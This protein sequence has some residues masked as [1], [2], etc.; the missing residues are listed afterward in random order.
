MERIF[1]RTPVVDPASRL[2]IFI[3]D[4]SYLPSPDL[5]NYD[6]F[7]PT[8]MKYLPQEPYALV[9]FNCGL[10]KVPWVW[11]IKFLKQFLDDG[12]YDN[13]SRLLKIYTV[14]DSWFVRSVT[15]IFSTKLH[16][17]LLQRMLDSFTIAPAPTSKIVRCASLSELALHLDITSLKISLNVYKYNRQ[18][19]LAVAPPPSPPLN[20]HHLYQLLN[21]LDANAAKCELIFHKPGNK[22]NTDILQQC[23][24]RDQLIWINDWDLWCIATLFKRILAD[25]PQALLPL[26]SIALP[27]H[28]DLEYTMG[29]WDL[30]WRQHHQRNALL[31]YD[32]LLCQFFNLL[33]TLVAH[34]ATTKH[35]TTLL[36]RCVSHCLSHEVVLLNKDRI[37][38]VNRFVRNVLDNWELIAPLH[39][40]PSVAELALPHSAQ[41][42][43]SYDVSYNVTIDNDDEDLEYRVAFNTT[44]ILSDESLKAKLQS[45]A[46]PVRREAKHQPA[47][48]ISQSRPPKSPIR[49]PQPLPSTHNQLDTPPP[50]PM[51]PSPQAP[52]KSH[53]PSKSVIDAPIAKAPRHAASKL[54]SEPPS[55]DPA[56]RKPLTNLKDVSNVVPQFP[57]Q[58]YRFA[59]PTTSSVDL[60]ATPPDSAASER[61]TS[62]V[63]KPVIRGRKVGELAR[64]FEERAEALEVLK[65]MH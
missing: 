19:D 49:T 7:I 54:V 1:Y 32:E 13:L 52:P 14:H 47:T 44:T 22:V 2:P 29:S 15:Q 25:L 10:N 28:D 65:T 18:V 26:E 34:G 8:L 57:P 33:H 58:K 5:I 40:F 50:T 43:N 31:H 6:L 60:T 48:R 51:R 61:A 45:P 27:I 36:A 9:M 63:K 37:S 12:E 17:A 3:F 16:L 21:I 59:R 55:A 24:Y 41:D 30:V 11:G 46:V 23:I 4:T 20:P 38:I 35:T 62:P 42:F 53:A 56:P 64:L 39:R